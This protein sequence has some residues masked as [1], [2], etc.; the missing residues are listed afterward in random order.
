MA[1]CPPSTTTALKARYGVTDYRLSLRAAVRGLW[2]GEYDLFAFVEAM[3]S[4]ITRGFKAA[5]DEGAATCGIHPEEYTEQEFQEL[6]DWIN[7]EL[8]FAP[9]FGQAIEEGSKANGGL[10][11]PQLTRVELWVKRYEAVKNRAMVLVCKDAKLKWIRDATE[12]C[13]SCIRLENQVRRAS[14]WEA[15]DVYP[16]HPDK[17]N[18]ML[19]AKGPSVCKCKFEQTDEPCT[20]GPLPSLP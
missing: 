19:S 16:Q 4:T 9:N 7:G 20:R 5:W 12:S 8:L 13:T 14:V 2:R 11:R 17:L 3:Q 1:C 18:C 15:S 6:D 10:L